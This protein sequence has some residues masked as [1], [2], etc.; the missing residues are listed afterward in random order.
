MSIR[1]KINPQSQVMNDYG[2]MM[3]LVEPDKILDKYNVKYVLYSR[4]GVLSTYLKMS[5]NWEILY[6]SEEENSIL[7]VRSILSE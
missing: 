1:R 5:P 4:D 3:G 6:E 2:D 7:F